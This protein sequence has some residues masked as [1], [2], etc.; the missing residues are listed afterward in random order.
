MLFLEFINPH[1]KYKVMSHFHLS[2][3]GE[4]WMFE[5]S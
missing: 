5:K 2:Y 4:F 3:L 1:M